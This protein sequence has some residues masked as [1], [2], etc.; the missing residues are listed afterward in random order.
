MTQYGV[1]KDGFVLKGLAEILKSAQQ[2]AVDAFGPEVDLGSTSVLTKLLQATAD[3]DAMLW[4]RLEDVYYSQ[5]A[6]TASGADLDLLGQ[7][8]GLRRNYLFS[9]GLA[10][11]TIANA[12]AGQVYALPAGT[13]VLDGSTPVN[14]YY[15]TAPVTLTSQSPKATVLVRAFEPGWQA[16]IEPGALTRIDPDYLRAQLNFPDNV[17]VAAVNPAAFTGGSE[18]EDD[19]SFRNR[20]LGF[21]RDMWTLQSVRAAALGVRGVV[22][23]LLSDSLG[24]VDVTQSFFG[25]FF[26][27]ERAFSGERRFGEPYFFDVVVAHEFARP[28]RT[29]GSVVGIYERVRAEVDRVRPVGIHPNIIEANHIEIGLRATVVIERGQDANSLRAA[30]LD[31]LS[32]SIGLLRLGGDVLYSQVMCVLA[33]QPGVVDVRDLRLRRFPPVLGRITFGTELFGSE[34][35][36]AGVGENLALGPTEIALFRQDSGLIDMQVVGR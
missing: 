33:E 11:L 23:V 29:T 27:S 32:R 17:T 14:A 24:G 6:S 8:I 25:Q 15:T 22:D 36:E 12:V 3:E 19:T 26:F 16:D 30:L 34:P 28:W 2:R 21:P 5:F 9:Q 35:I 20:Q 10:E 18:L 31:R 1:T 7:D 13:V 4:Q